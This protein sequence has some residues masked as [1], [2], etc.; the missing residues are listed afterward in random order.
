MALLKDGW[1]DQYG[2]NPPIHTLGCVGRIISCHKLS[3]GRYNIVLQGL[4]RCFYEEQAVE[5][6][7]RQARITPWTQAHPL[8]LSMDVRC[9]LEAVAK[10]YLT[11]KK[12]NQL[13][14][15]IGSGALTDSSLVQNL[16]A[17]L[18]LS[19]TEKQFLLESHDLTQQA[20]RLVDLIRFKLAD[21]RTAQG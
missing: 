2:G 21:L 13:C 16:S 15:V 9:G 17:G 1:E 4:G 12:A 6:S 19:P 8:S 18:D 5:T 20:R 10:E 7:Y 14:E 11:H 3:D